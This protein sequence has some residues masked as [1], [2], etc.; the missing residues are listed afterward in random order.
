MTDPEEPILA[1]LQYRTQKTGSGCLSTTL[2]L[3]GG[4]GTLLA[5]AFWPLFIITLPMLAIGWSCDTK[6]SRIY[7]CGNCGNDVSPT[8]TLCPHCRAQLVED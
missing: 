1:A 5:F 4:I 7:F 8:S 6:K 3:T 2:L